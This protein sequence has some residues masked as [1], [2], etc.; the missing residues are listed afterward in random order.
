MAPS[1][2]VV[3]EIYGV[4]VVNFR[5]A[6]I[7]DG[8]TVESIGDELYALVDEKARRK[9]VLDFTQ[10]KFLSSTMLG[11]LLNLH[12]KA[13][14]IKGKVLICGLRSKLFKVFKVMNLHKL[15]SFAKDEQEAL[16]CFNV[17]VKP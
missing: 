16:R 2:L 15:M 3:T 1:G 7:L 6:S 13:A 8:A 9:L 14:A 4:T 11:V 10:V 5:H 17:F 12:K